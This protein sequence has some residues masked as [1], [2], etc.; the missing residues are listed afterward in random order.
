SASPKRQ[1]PIAYETGAP[2]LVLV[3]LFS[4][5]TGLTG[6][7]GATCALSL[8][9]LLG[10]VALRVRLVLLRFTLPLQIVAA[11]HRANGLLRLTLDPL[12]DTADALCRTALV[13][14]HDRSFSRISK[15]PRPDQ[16][17]ARDRR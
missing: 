9:F 6:L 15:R 8:R 3:L 4:L 13:V 14:S 1:G 2:D 16:R 7:G 11:G 17:S 10:G 5:L 12:H